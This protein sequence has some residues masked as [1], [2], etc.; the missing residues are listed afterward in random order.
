M[1]AL[2]IIIWS[3]ALAALLFY[4]VRLTLGEP[5]GARLPLCT[6]WLLFVFSPLVIFAFIVA[7]S[8]MALIFGFVLLI[9]LA[10]IGERGIRFWGRLFKRSE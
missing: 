3:V 2:G 6:Y 7:F 5:K 4:V 9:I 8:P 10:L 1:S